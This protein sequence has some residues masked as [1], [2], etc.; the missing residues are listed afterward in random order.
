ML[1]QTHRIP[2]M[3]LHS[4]EFI[5]PLDYNQPDGAQITVY[6]RE[7]VPAGQEN[8]NLPMLVFFQG[9]PGSGAPRPTGKQWL[10]EAGA[11]GVSGVD[12]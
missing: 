8:T 7:L 10:V 5:L 9:G 12:A 1:T 2:G 3:V 6:A 4:H 11:T